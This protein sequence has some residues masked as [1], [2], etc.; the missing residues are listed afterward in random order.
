M[1]QP[2]SCEQ[3]RDVD[4][5]A[6]ED[7]KMPSVLLMENA[8]RGAVDVLEAEGIGGPIVICAGK[9]NNGG[10]GFVMARHLENRG[11]LVRVLLFSDPSALRGDAAINFEI[12]KA[13][14]TPLEVFA[15]AA[16]AGTLADRFR[17]ADWIVDA[18]LG[19]GTQG[20]IREPFL[21]IIHAMN[22]S[23]AK[24]LAVDLPSGMDA[25]TGQPVGA[26]VKADVTATFAARKI[27]FDAPLASNLTGAVHVVD[28]GV[29][30]R[31]LED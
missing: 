10:D 6:V 23:S 7:F 20:G 14:N 27:G 12:L 3:V 21:T 19:T 8:G 13:A 4:R 22:N 5:R 31:A 16:D 9:G 18:L 15:N 30:R 24:V 2:L 25:D 28:I 17:S 26:C 1:S 11:H 29:P